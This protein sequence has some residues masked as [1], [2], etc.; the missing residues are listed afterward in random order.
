MVPSLL[1]LILRDFCHVEWYEV[2]ELKAAVD[3]GVAKFDI[4]LFRQEL[5]ECILCYPAIPIAEINSLTGNEFQ[6]QDEVRQWLAGI[7]QSVFGE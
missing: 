5:A 3:S 2:K 1:A 6:T 4:K 7:R